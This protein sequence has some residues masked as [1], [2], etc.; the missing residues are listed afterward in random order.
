MPPVFTFV[1]QLCYAVLITSII[2]YL[3]LKYVLTLEFNRSVFI[4]ITVL[5][6]RLL[7][8]HSDNELGYI[9]GRSLING[10]TDKF[11]PSAGNM[12]FAVHGDDSNEGQQLIHHV[13]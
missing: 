11:Q 2:R 4:M 3:K 6:F 5:L 7:Y 13:V 1:V 9:Q 10:E 8:C 12:D